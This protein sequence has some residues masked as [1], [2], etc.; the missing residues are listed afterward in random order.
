MDRWPL[1]K[2]YFWETAPFFRVL[3]PFIAGIVCYDSSFMSMAGRVVIAVVCIAF[4]TYT[5]VA[6]RRAASTFMMAGGSLLLAIFLFGCGYAVSYYNDIRND[7]Y[8]FGSRVNEKNACL[9]ELADAPAEKEYA[10]KIPVRVIASPGSNKLSATTGSA[11]VYVYKGRHPL[12]FHKGDC[13]WAPAKW[14]PIKNAGNPFEFD[15]AG[16]CKRNN[17]FFQQF[18][19]VHD[20]RLYAKADTGAIPL[21][22]RCHT[23]CMKQLETY[24]TDVKTRGLIQAMLLGDEVNLDADIRQ[25]YADT[26]II[27]IIAISGGNVAIFF[28]VISFL[29]RWLRHKRHL[30]LKYTIALPLVWFYVFMAGAPP[31]AVRA[32][33]M[34]SLMAFAVMGQKS[35]N[36]LNQLLATAFLLLCAQPMWLFSVGFQLSFVAVLSLVVFYKPVYKWISPVNKI[37]RALWSTAAASI[38]AEVLV[39]PLVIYY[40]HTFPLLFLVANVAAYLFMSLV[41][42]LGIAIVVLS[43]APPVAHATGL[44]TE[45]LVLA[46]HKI[47][48]WLQGCNPESF[49]FLV[50]TAG[51]LVII[52]VV[53]SGAASYFL[54]KQKATLFTALTACCLLICLLCFDEWVALRQRFL[55]V[56]NAGKANHCE[57][58][59]GKEYRIP[60][61]SIGDSKR[62]AYATIPAHTYWHA[63]RQG[64][65]VREDVVEINNKSVLILSQQLNPVTPFHVDYLVVSESEPPDPVKLKTIFSP[66]VVV[67]SSGYTRKQEQEF[68]DA[69]VA[70][71]IPVHSVARNGA[72]VLK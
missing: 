70:A 31:S 48:N 52:Y 67:L 60:G 49:H 34:F 25:S 26:G 41:L 1:R 51:E 54:R 3:L 23:W 42:I 61:E 29:L 33:I 8:W 72:F 59:D 62:I 20:L 14:Q 15:Y 55:V 38:A 44:V 21:T 30:W 63:W 47:V 32:A 16:Y 65:P 57:L 7:R 4:I 56:Y 71:K 13:V 22:D 12:L 46:F 35:N 6:G 9:I 37:A 58:I 28:I 45:G 39:A 10:W 69:C 50:L 19:D 64:A 66:A 68:C 43:W 24:I 17:I 53:I 40:F 36:S 27:H 2:A 11:F 5:S 18:C